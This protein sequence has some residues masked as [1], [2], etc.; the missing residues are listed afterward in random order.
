MD[1]VMKCINTKVKVFTCNGLEDRYIK[2]LSKYFNCEGKIKHTLLFNGVEETCMYVAPKD[3]YKAVVVGCNYLSLQ[4]I[5]QVGVV[6]PLGEVSYNVNQIKNIY[7]T[8]NSRYIQ[9]LLT[10]LKYNNENDKSVQDNNTDNRLFDK[11]L[12]GAQSL[13]EEHED[14]V[15]NIIGEPT[16]TCVTKD[17]AN[18][19]IANTECDTPCFEN[20]EELNK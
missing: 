18:T 11:M 20:I 17:K 9:K 19:P 7:N 8:N 2:Y 3:Y 13:C 12:D 15:K 10:G 1:E 6:S 14:I 4:R 5:K 16:I